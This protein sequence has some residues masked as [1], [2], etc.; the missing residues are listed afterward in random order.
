[1]EAI[2]VIT[3]K[4][5]SLLKDDAGNNLVEFALCSCVW[6]SAVFVIV[7][8]S[9]TLYAAHFVTTAA[10]EAARYAIVRGSAWNGTTCTSPA[11]FDCTASSSDVTSFVTSTLPPG[12]D[13]AN[14]SVSTSWPGTTSSGDTC[15][16]ENGA[17][18]QNCQVKVAVSYS[19][20]MA[21]PFFPANSVPM[22]SSSE[23]TIAE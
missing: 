11:S 17:N 4:I 23:M 14:L 12:I 5:A 13:A 20:T 10:S 7:N 3:Q 16:S 9:F 6:C 22:T 8:L 19:L 21:L 15:D 1:V 2:V 18:S